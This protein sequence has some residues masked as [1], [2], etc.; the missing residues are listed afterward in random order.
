M[1]DKKISQLTSAVL[2]LA[3]TEVVPVVQSGATVKVTAASLGAAAAYTPAGTGAVVT[4]VQSKL[5]ESVSV[6]DFMTAEQIADVKAGT[7][8]Q[9]V[10]AAFNAAIAYLGALGGVIKVPVGRYKVTSTI[11]LTSGIS[12]IGDGQYSGTSISREGVT[13][14]WAVHTGVAILSLKGAIG[15]TVSD[16]ALEA[17]SGAIPKTGLLLGRSSAASA[18]YHKIK[19]VAIYGYYSVAPIYSIASEDNS[20]YDVNVWLFGGGAKYCLYTG[21]SDALST[22]AGL[23]TSSNLENT[24]YRPFFVNSST[25]ANA[26][27][28]FI[29]GAQAVGSWS[30]IGGYLTAYAG[31]YIQID[32]GTVDAQDCLG[33]FTFV[34]MSGEILQG[35]DPLY[36]IRLTSTGTRTL[37]G[38]T[39][40][41]T[42]FAFLAG[43]THYQIVQPGNLVL[44]SP[45]IHIQPPEAFPYALCSV[46]RNQIKN[47]N[48]T[49]GRAQAWTAITLSG[50]WANVYGSPYAQA[51]YSVDGFGV[52]RLRGTIGGGSATI[53]TLPSDLRPSANMFFNV[54]ATGGVGR[55]L[56]T[57][58]T[59]V[60]NLVS[61]TA[62]EVDL[63]S[64]QFNLV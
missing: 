26:A 9:D 7:I 48:V 8:T 58:A 45:S 47:G 12:L 22:G 57:A 23:T 38:L 64:I 20:W 42:R 19:Q 10:T 55:V 18:G 46:I 1:A 40:A 36:G 37:P 6:F 4:T 41:G 16:L 14:I 60:V 56:V 28:I 30:F 3:G 63:S 11:Q 25:D 62:T 43:T 52:V 21:I 39:V 59:G 34:A 61:G 27:C 29:Q 50:S 54:Y 5:R 49:V 32:N 31:S 24:F 35:G 44:E 53:F 33:P 2:P 17:G 13:S 51:G 15:C